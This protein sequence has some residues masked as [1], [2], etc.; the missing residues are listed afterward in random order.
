MVEVPLQS[1]LAE[2]A[3]LQDCLARVESFLVR[4]EAVLCRFTIMPDVPTLT[5]FQ[6][7]SVVESEADTYGCFSPRGRHIA[8]VDTPVIQIMP[9]LQELCEAPSQPLSTMLP[10][11][12]GFVMPMS[13]SS[14]ACPTFVVVDNEEQDS[15][16]ACKKLVTP[17]YIV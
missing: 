8:K 15:P 2:Q 13:T 17:E 3:E 7:H 6:V 16:M 14:P 4:A 5:E 1:V 11:E 12:M 9:G 10:K